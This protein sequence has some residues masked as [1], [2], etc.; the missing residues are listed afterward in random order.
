MLICHEGRLAGIGR[1][2][3]ASDCD[4]WISVSIFCFLLVFKEPCQAFLYKDS[5][6]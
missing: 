1:A 5:Q 2:C 4:A 6:C 3:N